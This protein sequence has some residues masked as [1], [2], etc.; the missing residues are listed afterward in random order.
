MRNINEKIAL[1]PVSKL[2]EHPSNARRGD[3]TAIAESI[4]K[5]GFYGVVVAQKGTGHVLAGNHR[6]RAAV[7]AGAEKIPV[8]WVDVDDAEAKRIMVADNRT[9]DLGIYDDEQLAR[10]LDDLHDDDMLSGT[11][12]D[13]SDL[14]DLIG[15]L[16]KTVDVSSFSRKPPGKREENDPVPQPPK[17]P[18]TKLGD[19]WELGKH[20]LICGDSTGVDVL[21]TLMGDEQARLWLTDPPYN[22]DYKG[23]TIEE[24]TIKNDSMEDEAFRAF[25]VDAYAAADAVLAPG[26]SFYIWHADIE[27]YNFRGACRDVGWPVRQCLIWAKNTL[28]LGRQDYQ[29]QHEPCLYGWKPGAAHTWC[30]DRKQT[31]LLEFDKPSRS[32]DYPTMKPIDLF[33]YQLENSTHQGEAVLDSFGGSGTTV[34]ACERAQRRAFVCE[35]DP[36]YCDVIVSRWEAFTGKKAVLRR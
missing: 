3:V 16:G 28:V 5:N 24:L 35:L 4:A 23:K 7:Q 29:W 18:T 25:L 27:G 9:S 33:Q 32:S 12:Y 30:S 21:R 36:A 26:A 22:V 10:L 31:T 20:R 8:A 14:D 2:T 11:G 13:I 15:D 34:I 1:T 6:L 19:V 17:S